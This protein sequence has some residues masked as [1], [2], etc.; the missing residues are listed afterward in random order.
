MFGKHRTL[1]LVVASCPACTEELVKLARQDD[2]VS[3]V[4]GPPEFAT[5]V[6]SEET[7]PEAMFLTAAGAQFGS[8]AHK[9]GRH[10]RGQQ[11]QVHSSRLAGT[12][13]FKSRSLECS[14]AFPDS[15]F[16][17][18]LI[19]CGKRKRG[20]FEGAGK[21]E[22]IV[23][24]GGEFGVVLGSKSRLGGQA[25]CDKLKKTRLEWPEL[26]ISGH[27]ARVTQQMGTLPSESWSW[28][29]QA[30]IHAINHSDSVTILK[31]RCPPDSTR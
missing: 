4:E 17:H 21:F 11:R 19:S 6:D 25:S 31:R 15:A 5:C 2:R 16:V 8:E 14:L 20:S 3:C 24:R 12:R 10:A 18:S 22:D 23:V 9:Q 26:V 30:D 29:R 28:R 27:N 1:I 7:N 13:G